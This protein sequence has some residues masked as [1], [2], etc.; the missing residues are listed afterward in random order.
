MTK[1]ITNWI[2]SPDES[3]P[4]QRLVQFPVESYVTRA[5]YKRF[6]EFFDDRFHG[7]HVGEDLEADAWWIREMRNHP[8][9]NPATLYRIETDIGVDNVPEG[10]PTIKD[11]LASYAAVQAVG[12]GVVTYVG[13][14]SGYGGVIVINH[15]ALCGDQPEDACDRVS[16]VYGHLN[17]DAFVVRVGDTVVKGDVIGYMGEEGSQTDGERAHLHFVVYKGEE[18]RLEGY[19]KTSDA[20]ADY[21]NP[22]LFFEAYGWSYDDENRTRPLSELIE[23]SGAQTFG[24]ID[25]EIPA[26]WDVEWV[27]SLEAWNL[28]DSR[29]AGSA[30]ERSQLFVRYFDAEKFLTLSTV[31]IHAATDVTVGQ[32]RYTARRYDIEKKPGVPDFADQPSWRNKRHVVTDFRDKEGFTRYFVVAARPDLNQKTYERVLSS[33]TNDDQ[34]TD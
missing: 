28:Y 31:A 17:P 33:V 8:G 25:M 23:P 15:A 3:S 1:P 19:V 30:R 24:A 12:P 5:R 7:Y 18:V 4:S 27:P 34:S 14:V 16:A 32:G 11:D 9:F 26:A 20:L 22:R 2:S 6:G 13:R 10:E 29:G 21:V